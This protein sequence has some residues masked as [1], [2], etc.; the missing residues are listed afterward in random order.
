MPNQ[1]HEVKCPFF[2]DSHRV[3]SAYGLFCE[4]CCDGVS[5]VQ[6][7]D[8]RDQ[9]FKFRRYFCECNFDRCPYY[10]IAIMKYV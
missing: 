5:S 4:G 7:F 10:D 2:K 9:Y 3:F 6:L 1:P 8:E